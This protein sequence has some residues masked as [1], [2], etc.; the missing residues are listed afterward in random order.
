[1]SAGLD[2][3]IRKVP[4]SFDPIDGCIQW[5]NDY[6]NRGGTLLFVSHNL[7]LVRN[8][9][10]RVVWLN[11]GRVVSDGPSA[12]VIPE[13]VKALE[14]RDSE[15]ATF[16]QGPAADRLIVARGQY[17]WGAGG[18]KVEGVHVGDPSEDATTLDI[19]IAYETSELRKAVFCVG[20]VD[21][22]GHEIGVTA[23]PAVPLEVGKGRVQCSLDLRQ[24]RPGSD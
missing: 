21:E 8:M 1:M 10:D 2:G 22:G 9:T 4:G 12:S 11:H 20:F 23:S 3:V 5:L 24:F 13:Y 15:S 19:T 18:A 17:R 14:L 6:K 16:R 7:S